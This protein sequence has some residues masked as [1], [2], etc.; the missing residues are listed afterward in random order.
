MELVLVCVPVRK[1]NKKVAH[2]AVTSRVVFGKLRR[3]HGTPLCMPRYRFDGLVSCNR[4]ETL[5]VCKRCQEM[6]LKLAEA[7]IVK[8]CILPQ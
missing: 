4:K 7:G 3:N 8:E 1:G 6:A 5:P 2:L